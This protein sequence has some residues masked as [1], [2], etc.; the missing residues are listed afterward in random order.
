M[1]DWKKIGKR[2]IF[3][4]LWLIIALTIISAVLLVLV[5]IKGWE[6]TILGYTSYTI[7]FYSLCVL[8]VFC[9]KVL[10]Y[11]VKSAKKKVYENKYGN[12]FLTDILFRAHFSLYR[13]LCIN[14][15]YIGVNI[16]CVLIYKTIWF[17]IFALYYVI[18]AVMRFLLLK[19]IRKNKIASNMLEEW[20]RARICACI[21]VLINLLLSGAILMMMYQNRGFEYYGILIYIM[22]MYSFYITTVAVMNIVKYRKYNSPV[23][24]SAGN[25]SLAAALV[26]MLSLE[27]GMLSAFG[28]NTPILTKRI[29]IA[30]TGAGIAVV[31]I[32]L[33]C[34]MIT[35]S[36]LEIRK[37][38][39]EKI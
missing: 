5:S 4:P 17:A 8:T 38:K 22:A 25:V 7:S 24:S 23:L 20:K 9:I 34:Y 10:P 36:T 26:S 11:K 6:E 32:T 14:L 1:V 39:T 16:A 15:L 35:K 29:L 27:T 19:Y 21:L 37:I 18:L 28:G 30:S 31:L 12:R 13:S 33:S 2:S 3:L